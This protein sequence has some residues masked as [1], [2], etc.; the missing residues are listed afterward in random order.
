MEKQDLSLM[1]GEVKLNIRVG[2]LLE[3]NNKILVEKNKTVDF[4]VV[5]GG[6][7]R[8]LE[9]G[10]ETL[11]RELKDELN[12]DLSSEQ[13]ELVSLIENFFNF[14]N[15]TYHEL[16]FV[17]RVKLT[18]NY[19][20]EDAYKSSDNENSKF[21]WYTREEFEKQNILPNVLKEIIHNN[22]FKNYIVNDLNK[23]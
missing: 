23:K 10:P 11:K 22:T 7:M 19:G 15:K 21:Y 20:I 14:D 12:V 17:Y 4:G 6:R 5:P 2:V 18:N 9:S 8:T 3:Y 1:L 16:Y 13:F